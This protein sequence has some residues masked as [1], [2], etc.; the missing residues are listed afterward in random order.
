[1][2]PLTFENSFGDSLTD[3]FDKKT[4]V[5]LSVNLFSSVYF[6]D[7]DMKSI[8]EFNTMQSNISPKSNI[9]KP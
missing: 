7:L 1:M 8:T 2:K 9:D 6:R 5:P 4:Y 3:V